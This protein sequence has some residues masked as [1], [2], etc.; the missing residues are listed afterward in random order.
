MEVTERVQE[1]WVGKQEKK[2]LI[3]QI[4][5]RLLLKYC[6]RARYEIT[7]LWQD[8]VTAVMILRPDAVSLDTKPCSMVD[9]L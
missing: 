6:V 8:P 2:K 5:A 3:V 4:D 9:I 1:L 7:W